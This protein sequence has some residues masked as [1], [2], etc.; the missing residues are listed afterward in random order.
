MVAAEANRQLYRLVKRD[1]ICRIVEVGINDLSRAVAKDV[2]SAKAT[3]RCGTRGSICS[4][5]S[6][7]SALPIKETYRNLRATEANVGS[8]PARRIVARGSYRTPEYGSDFDGPD[9]LTRTFRGRGFMCRGC[10]Q[11]STI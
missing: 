5:P 11:T 10:Q 3:R 1:Q 7:G 8:C 9:V 4:K 6:P 2:A